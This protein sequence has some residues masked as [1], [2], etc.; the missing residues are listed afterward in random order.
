MWLYICKFKNN[1]YVIIRKYGKIYFVSYMYTYY[2]ITLQNGTHQIKVALWIYIL[3]S[4]QK[5][6]VRNFLRRYHSKSR[7]SCC[8]EWYMHSSSTLKISG[9]LVVYK[10]FYSGQVMV[11]QFRTDCTN[12]YCYYNTISLDRYLRNL[13]SVT[14]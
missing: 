13:F 2:C 1:K 12:C 5:L 4:G 8:N 6:V 9:I 14:K 10:T 3:N 7:N 11:V